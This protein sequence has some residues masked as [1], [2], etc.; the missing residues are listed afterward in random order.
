MEKVHWWTQNKNQ[1]RILNDAAEALGAMRDEQADM[2]Q[3]I[4]RLYQLDKDQGREIARLQSVVA[5]LVD[6]IIEAE[7]VPEA[8]L[9]RRLDASVR[10]VDG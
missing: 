10:E 1:T 3:Q 5:T 6:L 4:D 7:V 8:E 9:I 2:E